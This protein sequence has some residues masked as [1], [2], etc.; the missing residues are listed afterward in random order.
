MSE[1]YFTE[2]VKEVNV[3]ELD[4]VDIL[5]DHSYFYNRKEDIIEM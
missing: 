4:Q 5:S 3:E 2:M 1:K